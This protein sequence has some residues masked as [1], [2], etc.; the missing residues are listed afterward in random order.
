MCIVC[1]AR[2]EKSQLIRVVKN[3]NGEIAVDTTHKQ[4]G[5]GA[6]ICGKTCIEK[7]LKSRL[8]NRAFKREVDKSVYEKISAVLEERN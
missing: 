4:E 2:F 6:Y 5:R 8:I 3:K 7:C 1:R